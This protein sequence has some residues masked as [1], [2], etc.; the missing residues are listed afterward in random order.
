MVEVKNLTLL[1]TEETKFVVWSWEVNCLNKHIW[2]RTI[3][4]TIN[5]LHTLNTYIYH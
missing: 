3:D 2:L 1:S 5:Y 4:K